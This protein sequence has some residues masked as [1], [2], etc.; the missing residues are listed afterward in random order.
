M[1]P[2]MGAV[3]FVMADY[4]QVDYVEVCIA[5]LIPSVL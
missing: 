2:V 1:P 5:A 3:A 4:L